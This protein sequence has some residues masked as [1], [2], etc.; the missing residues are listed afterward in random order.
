M[1]SY[2]YERW[3]SFLFYDFTKT[4]TV[5]V[6][7]SKDFGNEITN[8]NTWDFYWDSAHKLPY[9]QGDVRSVKMWRKNDF[10]KLK[11][12]ARTF[13]IFIEPIE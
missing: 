11:E 4:V 12:K 10:E 1:N 5:D 8:K 7:D 9:L 3:L 2:Y 6:K 13:D